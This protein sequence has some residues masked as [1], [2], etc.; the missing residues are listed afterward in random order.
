M[1]LKS[2]TITS[3]N[4]VNDFE[5]ITSSYYSTENSEEKVGPNSFNLICM[6]GKG[7]FGEVY[8]VEKNV[9]K[10][11]YAM[12]VLHKQKILSTCRN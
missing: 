7:S 12:K 10:T 4:S 8:L 2:N 11:V 6:L 3:N 1:P 9:M 5:Q